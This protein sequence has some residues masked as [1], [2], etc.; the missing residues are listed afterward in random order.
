MAS[1]TNVLLI[2]GKVSQALGQVLNVE[3]HCPV[4]AAH[5]QEAL[6]E[7]GRRRIDV[8]G[9][10]L[11][12]RRQSG[13]TTLRRPTG[14]QPQVPMVVLGEQPEQREPNSS[15]RG[16]DVLLEKILNLAV[17]I[18]ALNELASPT[19]ETGRRRTGQA[20]PVSG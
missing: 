18:Q 7:W 11:T 17:L 10:D 12:S 15:A 4:A 6:R 3:S 20:R 9:C 2:D 16:V 19:P 13:R 1:Q 14:L 8:A 5:R